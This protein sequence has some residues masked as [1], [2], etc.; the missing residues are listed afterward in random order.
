MDGEEHEP[1]AN[2]REPQP[3][4][5]ASTRQTGTRVPFRPATSTDDA[6]D[7]VL[8]AA[9]RLLSPDEQDRAVAAV[10]EQ[11]IRH[12]PGFG[13][14]ADDQRLR[15]RR[16]V[17]QQVVQGGGL[18]GEQ[19]EHAYVA[20]DLRLADSDVRDLDAHRNAPVFGLLTA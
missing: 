14:L 4:R 10:V 8:L 1:L 13:D 18:L 12:F 9:A 2:F 20:A 6:K 15:R 5:P 17:E 7:A 11:E 3:H 16:L 19:R